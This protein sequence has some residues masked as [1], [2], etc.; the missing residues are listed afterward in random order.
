LW[1]R[2]DLDARRLDRAAAHAAE[3]VK[4][5]EVLKRRSDAA[6]ARALLGSIA[7]ATGD[8]AQAIDSL[9]AA[10]ASASTPLALSAH[11]L[12]HARA[13]AE[14]LESPLPTVATTDAP[15]TAHES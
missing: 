13:L 8:R 2:S 5:A 11:A 7:L 14:A 15:T 12:R 10:S 3:A 6:V 4:A 1:A 9:R